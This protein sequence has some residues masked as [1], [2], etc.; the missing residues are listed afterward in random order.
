MRKA[1]SF[2]IFFALVAGTVYGQSAS[3][4]ADDQVNASY[5]QRVKPYSLATGSNADGGGVLGKHSSGAVLGVD[6]VAELEQL[7]L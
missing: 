6:S 2:A 1:V 4:M 7:F 5:L 3:T